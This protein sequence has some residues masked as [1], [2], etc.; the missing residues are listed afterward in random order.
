MAD[1]KPYEAMHAVFGEPKKGIA[2]GQLFTS[3]GGARVYID[4]DG[5]EFVVYASKSGDEL[6]RGENILE[7]LESIEADGWDF[8]VWDAAYDSEF[9][10]VQDEDTWDPEYLRETAE[11]EL[12]EDEDEL[13]RV[14]ELIDAYDEKFYGEE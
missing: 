2:K 10:E 8:S 11:E 14:M 6:A 3:K 13:E 4:R 5:D 7:A 12:E 9:E 1:Y